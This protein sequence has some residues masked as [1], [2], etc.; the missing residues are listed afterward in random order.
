M[1]VPVFITLM[2]MLLITDAIKTG[3]NI[4]IDP[5]HWLLI[6]WALTK[7][8]FMEWV[9]TCTLFSIVPICSYCKYIMFLVSHTVH[10]SDA[11]SV[12]GLHQLIFWPLLLINTAPSDHF[13]SW[14]PSCRVSPLTPRSP[15]PP[16]ASPGPAWH[17]STCCSV[18]LILKTHTQWHIIHKARDGFCFTVFAV[19][20]SSHMGKALCVIVQKAQL[21][22]SRILTDDHSEA[23]QGQLWFIHKAPSAKSWVTQKCN[24]NSI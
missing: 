20:T 10:R 7:H 8:W 24:E 19:P 11:R 16:A 5:W 4:I 23:G 6:G 22:H 14:T 21:T 1:Y 12:C 2:K 13:Y 17:S 18:W 9:I 15:L 3:G